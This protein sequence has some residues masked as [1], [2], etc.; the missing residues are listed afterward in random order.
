MEQGKGWSSPPCSK[1]FTIGRLI[2]GISKLEREI[3][4]I[5]MANRLL[6]TLKPQILIIYMLIISQVYL[7][8]KEGGLRISL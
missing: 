5:V 4:K 6:T 1:L 3:F 7:V 2:N 8:T